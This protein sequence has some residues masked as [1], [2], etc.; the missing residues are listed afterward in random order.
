MLYAYSTGT[1]MKFGI[2]LAMGL[3]ASTALVG[4]ERA[5]NAFLVVEG[6]CVFASGKTMDADRITPNGGT[7]EWAF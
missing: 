5:V 2:L 7:V 3:A 1:K 6:G 4:A